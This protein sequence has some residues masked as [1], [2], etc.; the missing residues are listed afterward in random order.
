MVS[1][2]KLVGT[3]SCYGNVFRKGMGQKKPGNAGVAKARRAALRRSEGP[4][5]LPAFLV[6]V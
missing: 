3:F 5:P 1:S 6:C 2:E 4:G